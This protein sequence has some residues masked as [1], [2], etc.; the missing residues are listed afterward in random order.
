MLSLQTFKKQN[1]SKIK[2]FIKHF[3]QIS[4]GGRKQKGRRGH[5]ILIGNWNRS[6]WIISQESIVFWEKEGLTLKTL[7]LHASHI[8][9]RFFNLCLGVASRGLMVK[10]ED[11]GARSIF[12]TKDEPAAC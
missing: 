9:K 4:V 1:Y 7:L 5:F 3:F 6:A 2:I 8:T 12:K 10:A 11:S